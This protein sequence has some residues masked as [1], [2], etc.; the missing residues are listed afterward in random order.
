MENRELIWLPLGKKVEGISVDICEPV[1]LPRNGKKPERIWSL[2]R[3]RNKNLIPP[4]SLPLIHGESAFLEDMM[5]DWRVNNGRLFCRNGTG[6]GHWLVL[7][8]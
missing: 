2:T 4:K 7:E 5:N 3:F 1:N 6:G 8:Y